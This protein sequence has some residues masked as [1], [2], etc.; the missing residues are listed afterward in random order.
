MTLT[1]VTDA[2]GMVTEPV[3]ANEVAG[4]YTIIATV[5]GASGP[6]L[7]SMVNMAAEPAQLTV[8]VFA[9]PQT[10]L[11]RR[12]FAQ[13]LQVVVTDS[14]GNPAPNA[15]V[16]FTV[17]PANGA[18]AIL[19]AS[20]AS[21]DGAGLGRVLALAN[22]VIGSYT[23]QASLG[24]NTTPAI[25]LLSNTYAP[26]S[27]IKLVSGSNQTAAATTAFAK[28]VVF[29][30][31]D[32]DSQPVYNANVTFT[33]TPSGLAL[34]PVT[35]VSDAN[36]NVS[37]QVT[38]GSTVGAFQVS[39]T[40]PN[41]AT[42]AVANLTVVTVATT[43][44]I[45]PLGEVPLEGPVPLIATVMAAAGGVPQGLL[46]FFID[47]TAVGSVQVDS[48]GTATLAVSPPA[49]GTHTVTAHFDGN[50]QFLPSDA[51]GV[52]LVTFRKWLA[53]GSG[54]A[55]GFHGGSGMQAVWLLLVLAV[56]SR[57]WRQ[58]SIRRALPR[59]GLWLL[60]LGAV[61]GGAANTARAQ[62][63]TTTNFTASR[64]QPMGGA[65]D[66]LAVQSAGVA[67]HERFGFWLIA[68]YAH[69]QLRLISTDG[70]ELVLLNDRLAVDL[71]GTVGFGDRFELS[72]AVPISIFQNGSSAAFIGSSLN[73]GPS[74]WGFGDIRIT[75]KALI[76]QNDT[77][78][79]GF[80]LPISVPS[81]RA[82]AYTGYGT[83][84][85]NP[86]LALDLNT[87][88]NLRFIANAGVAIRPT[89]Q[90][91]QAQI[92]S[93]FTYGLGA[94]YLLAQY[95]RLLGTLQG[96]VVFGEPS[97]VGKPLEGLVAAGW[98]LARDWELLLGIGKGATNGYGEPRVRILAGITFFS[99]HAD[100]PPPAPAPV[101]EAPVAA[102]V[103]IAPPPETSQDPDSDADGV[104]DALDVCPQTPK[105]KYPDQSRQGC[106]MPDSDGD[107]VL[108]SNDTCPQVP[109]GASPD[110]NRPGCPE[111][112]TDGDGVPNSTDVCPTVPA[113]V[114]ADQN[115]ARLGC[116]MADRDNDGVP[117]AADAC[118]DV[119]GAPST[120]S[121]KNGCP[122]IVQIDNF[123]IRTLK[124]VLFATGTATLLPES[125]A[126]MEGVA[127][128]LRAQPEITKCSVE[129]HTDSKGDAKKNLAL[130]VARAKTCYDWLTAHG[131]AADRLESSG[132]G[133]DRPIA[134][135]DTSDGRTRNRRV[136]FKIIGIKGK[137]V[138]ASTSTPAAAPAAAPAK[139]GKSKAGK[140]AKRA[141]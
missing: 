102:P 57:W 82:S 66:I 93:A 119:K 78:R 40:N 140:A 58:R 73:S 4:P 118:P 9:T 113:G 64:F 3:A 72:L 77:W 1:A 49:L 96:E 94:D 121:K 120:D 28:P 62:A 54:C 60:L 45:A 24:P 109:A 30:V 47:G 115:P 105:G 106:P 88:M 52:S 13:P 116:P 76:W 112:D 14:F 91:V 55:A 23:A 131:I 56:V 27:V 135:N 41:V 137:S 19:S 46:H 37:V 17:Q 8:A 110:A 83:L 139:A 5:D 129:G 36:G 35:A 124:P 42:P 59:M 48:T 50:A 108:D 10:T 95:W 97:I 98:H 51:I 2:N 31:E 12:S 11:V 100:E 89:R 87:G 21:T 128:A 67:P 130:S 7:F 85:A 134:S 44:V 117:D 61:L 25:F 16:T 107:G 81:G 43:T 127:E 65:Y 68:N 99:P 70:Q 111:I 104:V 34:T 125:S 132:Y 20:S 126:V 75:P 86:E 22:L 29:L 15:T 69:N 138:A 71:G 103:V 84:T 6:V 26:A 122:G 136:D 53:E 123:Q 74:A 33:A 80:A 18:S 133:K 39:A 141:P 63:P 79:L 101:V 92:G 32:A 114:Y 90:Y 38:A